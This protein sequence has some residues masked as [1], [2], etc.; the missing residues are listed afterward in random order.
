ML[1]ANIK[2]ESKVLILKIKRS[3][4]LNLQMITSVNIKT[5]I[6]AGYILLILL[7]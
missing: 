7:E 1:V 4:Y 5:M 3:N 6:R 2:D